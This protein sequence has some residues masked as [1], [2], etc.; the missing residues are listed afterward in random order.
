[1]TPAAL[2]DE[3]RRH[4][5][6]LTAEGDRLVY[7]APRRL[8]TPRCGPR[9]SSKAELLALLRPRPTPTLRSCATSSAPVCA[10]WPPTKPPSGRRQR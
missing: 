3:C 7:R 9:S 5:V 1:M 6:V 10:S 2:L 4:S 8:L